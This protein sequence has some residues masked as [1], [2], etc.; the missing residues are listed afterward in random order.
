MGKGLISIAIAQIRA[1]ALGLY[2]QFTPQEIIGHWHASL[3]LGLPC[4]VVNLSADEF[5]SDPER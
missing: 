2:P 5:S 4:L 1:A 3:L